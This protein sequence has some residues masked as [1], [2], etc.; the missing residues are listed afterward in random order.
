MY[1]VS[2]REGCEAD[3]KEAIEVLCRSISELCEPDH[4]NDPD[5]ISDWISNKTERAWT[6][7]LA[8][9]DAAVY[10]AI[11]N[12]EIVGVGMVSEKGEVLLN[13]VS[14][15]A[16]FSG[17]SKAVLRTLEAYVRGKGANECFLESTVTA[18]KFYESFGYTS[19]KDGKLEL[20]KSI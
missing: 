6:T 17:V 8:R 13:Y 20:R 3:A 4:N 9:D 10:V 16:R 18:K 11:K 1:E 15:D 19:Q 5:E 14:P 12:N 2:I 7:W